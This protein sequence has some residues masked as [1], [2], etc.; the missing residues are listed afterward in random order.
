[1]TSELPGVNDVYAGLGVWVSGWVMTSSRGPCHVVGRAGSL[2]LDSPRSLT[3]ACLRVKCRL[4]LSHFN[5]NL[6]AHEHFSKPVQ[7]EILRKTDRWFSSCM[8]QTDGE[9]DMTYFFKFV[10]N[11]HRPAAVEHIKPVYRHINAWL[12]AHTLIQVYRV[13]QFYSFR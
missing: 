4:F 5:Q 13:T 2:Y 10:A 3:C 1:M 7:N 8:R 11:V 6:S 9:T 12:W